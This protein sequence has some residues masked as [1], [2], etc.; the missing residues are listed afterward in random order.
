MYNVD[1]IY[2]HLSSIFEINL[3]Y[4]L[5]NSSSLMSIKLNEI[6]WATENIP[7]LNLVEHNKYYQINQN[8]SISNASDLQLF[9]LID[10]VKY[11]AIRNTSSDPT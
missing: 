2:M 6:L 3:K 7:W 8:I 5:K 11:I 1:R 10:A 9:K 4:L